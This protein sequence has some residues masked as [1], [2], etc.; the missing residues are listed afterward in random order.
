MERIT[1]KC[2]EC[3]NRMDIDPKV[4]AFRCSQCGKKIDLDEK[5]VSDIREDSR[6]WQEFNQYNTSKTKRIVDE[7]KIKAAEASIE[8]QKAFW[9]HVDRRNAQNRKD[10]W[11]KIVIMLLI[12]IGCIA[13]LYFMGK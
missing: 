5:P 8:T 3:G 9:E 13:G 4:I 10:E 11:M 2:P 1:V 6:G 12:F 7:A